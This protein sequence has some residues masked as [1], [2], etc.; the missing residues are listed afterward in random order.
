VRRS[1]EDWLTELRD[2]GPSGEGARKDLRAALV[3]GLGR[4]LGGRA[5][6][7]I[8]DFAQESLVR[9][10]A[11]LDAFHEDSRFTTWA[12]S[13]AVRTAWTELRRSRWKDVSLE[14]LV[15]SGAGAMGYEPPADEPAAEKVVERE[16]VIAAL[17]RAIAEALTD[18]QRTV[19]VAEL[20]GM[21]QA[22]LC[23]RLGTNRNA[24]YKVSHDA[25]RAL[26]RALDERGF[27]AESVRFA[28]SGTGD[29]RG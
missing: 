1:N 21:P 11:S 19:I 9:V 23:A 26:L 22:E 8:E 20:R 4:A 18:R 7:E 16:R 2:D 6:G 12:M 13:I 14:A 25:R 29:H 10:L 24:L 15:A 3:A 17:E 27:D 28:F 5:A